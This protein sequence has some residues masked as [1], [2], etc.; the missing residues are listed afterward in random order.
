MKNSSV[1]QWLRNKK[2]IVAGALPASRITKH[3]NRLLLLFIEK[4]IPAKDMGT[5]KK[6]SYFIYYYCPFVHTVCT[7]GLTVLT[8][9]P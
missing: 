4:I 5:N 3:Y 1:I 9:G 2:T 6:K 7:V 8:I